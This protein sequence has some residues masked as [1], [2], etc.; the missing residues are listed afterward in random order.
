MKRSERENLHP[1]RLWWSESSDSGPSTVMMVIG[2][3]SQA[4]QFTKA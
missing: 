4:L 3:V 2:L 1:S